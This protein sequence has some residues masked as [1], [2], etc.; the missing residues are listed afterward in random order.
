MASA[1]VPRWHD[2]ATGLVTCV[3]SVRFD[4]DIENVTLAL[5]GQVKAGAWTSLSVSLIDLRT[6]ETTTTLTAS[7]DV[8]ASEKQEL[9][10]LDELESEIS[11][12]LG[13]KQ[14]D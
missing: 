9:G 6:K 11:K 5:V 13:V 12:E 1:S 4:I 3:C 2:A 8:L 10:K 7:A 14:K